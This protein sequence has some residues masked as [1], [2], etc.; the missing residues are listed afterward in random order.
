MHQQG[1]SAILW[2]EGGME[3]RRSVSVLGGDPRQLCLA[4]LFREEGRCLRLLAAA[5]EAAE[6]DLRELLAALAR[7]DGRHRRT[8]MRLAEGR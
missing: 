5:E 8:L 4:E 2:T 7:E 1:D 6:N 3:M